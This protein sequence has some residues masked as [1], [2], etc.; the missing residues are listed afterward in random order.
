MEVVKAAEEAET[1]CLGLLEEIEARGRQPQDA[2]LGTVA[3]G[4]AG[5]VVVTPDFGVG[6]WDY[7]VSGQNCKLPDDDANGVDV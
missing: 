7:M 4:M 5:E 3:Q 2:P 6:D 1:R